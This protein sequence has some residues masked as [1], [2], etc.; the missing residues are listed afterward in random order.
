MA[1]TDS[2]E[3][4]R[5][6]GEA[7]GGEP[8]EARESELLRELS[9]ECGSISPLIITLFSILMIFIFLI[10]N[11]ASAFVARRELINRVESALSLS[12]QELDELTY[13][14]ASPLT[15][16]MT[17]IG[18]RE[19]QVR[20]PIDCFN[21]R[22]TF[23]KILQTATTSYYTK[24]EAGSP[25]TGVEPTK[26]YEIEISTFSCDG[27]EL[28]ATVAETRVLPFQVRIFDLTTFTNEVSASNSSFLLSESR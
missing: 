26:R 13:Y 10:S 20:V 2:V 21:A 16:F 22:K 18:I 24:S 23:S 3:V 9:G 15:D 1:M 14:Y 25:I 8:S 28:T 4:E 27:Y 6:K 7:L 11:V 19:N 12:A 5:E 17:E